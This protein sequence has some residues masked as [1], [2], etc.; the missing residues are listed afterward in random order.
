VYDPLVTNTG[1]VLNCTAKMMF[2]FIGFAL[3]GLN[4]I[5]SYY[6]DTRH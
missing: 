3:S 4:H 5:V 1:G 2:L 6:T